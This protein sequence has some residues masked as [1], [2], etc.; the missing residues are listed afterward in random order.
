MVQDPTEISTI[1]KTDNIES[2]VEQ[3]IDAAN[4]YGGHDNIGVVIV[5][6]KAPPLTKSD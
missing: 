3:L 2:A 4:G 5:D 1:M 6:F